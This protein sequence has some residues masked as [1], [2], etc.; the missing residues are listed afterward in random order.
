MLAHLHFIFRKLNLFCAMTCL[1]FVHVFL[2]SFFFVFAHI[3]NFILTCVQVCK[4]ACLIIAMQLL[5][6]M[7]PLVSRKTIVSSHWVFIAKDQ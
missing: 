7:R 6:L 2:L 4:C 3:S 1:S 5:V